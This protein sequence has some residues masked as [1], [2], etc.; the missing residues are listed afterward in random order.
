MYIKEVKMVTT[1]I[2]TVLFY[3]QTSFIVT[4]LILILIYVFMS[5][6]MKHT[7]RQLNEHIEKTRQSE[8]R[9]EAKIDQLVRRR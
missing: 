7:Y 1:N 8:K 4:S 6:F 9:I 3:I 5:L 2:S